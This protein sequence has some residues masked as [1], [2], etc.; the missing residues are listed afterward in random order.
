MCSCGFNRQANV[1]LTPISN[2]SHDANFSELERQWALLE[3]G[4]DVDEELAAM[5]VLLTRK[6]SS[7]EAQPNSE[8]ETSSLSDSAVDEELEALRKQIDNL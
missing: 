7:Q 6:S 2:T 1:K 8:E 3:S 5:K 4:S